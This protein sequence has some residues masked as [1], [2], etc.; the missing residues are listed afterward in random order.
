VGVANLKASFSYKSSACN[1]AKNK[2][3]MGNRN[4]NQNR[5]QKPARN[6][7]KFLIMVPAVGEREI[8]NQNQAGCCEKK[9]TRDKPIKIYHKSAWHTRRMRNIAARPQNGKSDLVKDHFGF[10]KISFTTETGVAKKFVL[11]I[12]SP[13]W[14]GFF[15]FF[16]GF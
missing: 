13:F 2:W 16:L 12:F 15:L 14:Q 9:Q 5:N 7:V 1:N 8:Q 10:I 3:E 6:Y 4:R 11:H